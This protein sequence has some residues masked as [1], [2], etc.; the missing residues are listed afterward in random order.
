MPEMRRPWN[1]R[2]LDKR[3]KRTTV[4]KKR[5]LFVPCSLDSDENRTPGRLIPAAV[6]V[7]L[8]G[9]IRCFLSFFLASAF[10]QAGVREDLLTLYPG[11]TPAA[12]ELRL[13]TL[14]N[15]EDFFRS[16]GPYFHASV[17][18]DVLS[19]PPFSAFAGVG[20]WCAGDPHPEN[21][22]ALLDPNGRPYFLLNDLD[23]TGPCPVVA[24]LLRLLTGWSLSRG[25]VDGTGP[26]VRAY[27][28]GF[29][30]EPA[31]M[32]APIT[33]FLR[34]AGQSGLRPK[35]S[36]IDA[37]TGLLK[38]KKESRRAEPSIQGELVQT[39]ARLFAGFRVVD[40]RERVKFD[41]GSGGQARYLVLLDRNGARVLVEFK[42]FARPSTFVYGLAAPEATRR[43]AIGWTWAQA[44]VLSSWNSFATVGG[45][46][47]FTRPLWDGNLNLSVKDFS[48]EAQRA[49]G[50]YE[51][52]L[53]GGLHRA[54]GVDARAM[55]ALESLPAKTWKDVV[56]SLSERMNAAFRDL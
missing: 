12:M 56:Q 40:L 34:A 4:L 47:F 28:A 27:F 30:G 41:G 19:R 14:K 37:R 43:I 36:W 33:D 18:S 8:A 3:E 26:L 10:A 46:L 29:R 9:M 16:F 13:R 42:E 20:S 52:W 5:D 39:A 53:L 11:Q 38:D 17:R 22:G 2:R 32:P 21:F 31:A 24:D 23:D 45:K 35:S 54:A 51:A 7:I 44:P 48:G 1:H 55:Q 25:E 49:I 50:L 6:D 15:G